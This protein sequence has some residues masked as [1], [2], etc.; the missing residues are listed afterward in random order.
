MQPSA[1]LESALYVADLD[2]DTQHQPVILPGAPCICVAALDAPL[3]FPGRLARAVQP[4][5]GI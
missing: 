1:I 2:A 5:F 3:R 4:V